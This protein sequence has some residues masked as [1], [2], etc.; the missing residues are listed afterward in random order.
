[1]I[2]KEKI[3]IVG[4]AG[5]VGQGIIKVFLKHGWDCEII[6]PAINI[7]FEKLT[8]SELKNTFSS[9]N[10]VVYAAEIGNRDLYEVNPNLGKENNLRFKNFCKKVSQINPQIT[11]WY[12]GG[13]WTKRKSNKK[14]LVTDNSPN[15]NLTECNPYEKAK[16][17]AEKNAKKLSKIINI[18]FLDWASIVP[19][20]SEN[21]SIS[22]MVKQA[23]NEG[24]ITYS[25]GFYGRPL[26]ESRQAG[27][28]LILLIKN[29]DK[30]RVFKTFLIPGMFIPFSKFAHSA[31]K[32]VEKETGKKI[33]LEKQT[34][35]PDFLKAKTRS[36]YLE[37]LGFSPKKEIVLNALKQNAFE[38]LNKLE[39]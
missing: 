1:M 36:A 11:I 34:T 33:K 6:D 30:S 22:K 14:W 4:G 21:F 7:A 35:P 12:V 37:K 8:I 20:L 16:I 24:K 3:V 17:S 2:V 32:V 18:R 9:V 28:A 10:H 19:N 5:N 39:N 25:P 27:E 26:L 31:R 23:L 15:K 29:N 13:S 38:F